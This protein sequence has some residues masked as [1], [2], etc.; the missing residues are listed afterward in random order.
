MNNSDD[1]TLRFNP[2]SPLFNQHIYQIYQRMRRQQPL[3]RIGRTWVLTR[4]QDVSAALRAPQ[5]SCSGI[6]RHL[7]AEF[8]RLQGGLAPE[9]AMLVQEMAL[10]QDNG[11]HRQHRKPLMALFSREPLAQLRR[12][13]VDEINR[14]IAALAKT[15]RLDVIVQLARPLWP[16]LFAR[17]LN[18]S[19]Q[20][21]QVIEQEKESIRLLLDPSAIDRAGLERL[22]SALRRLDT[23]FSQLYQECA[24]G[25]PS[26]FFAALVQGYGDQ[27]ALM[28]RYF[29]AD[30]V[31]ILIGGS[32]TT[33][34]LIGNLMQV[35]A[36]DEPLQQQLRQHPQWIAQAVQ[37]TLRYESPLQMARRTVI[38]PWTLH[39]RTLREQDAV[40]LCLGAANRDETQFCDAQ[41]FDLHRENNSRHLGFGGSAHLCAGQLL[42]RFQA[43]SV[44]AALLQHF[45]RLRPLEQAQW[46][47]DSLIL[48]SLKS[49]PLALG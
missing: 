17:W 42:A 34:A 28:Q 43:E 25:R 14:S 48:R 18:L 33:E 11:T 20:Q 35:V 36:Q 31:T 44:C 22:A 8:A 49:L 40:L 12:L 30:C 6:P 2:A 7:T 39:G 29:S 38:H 3:L 4:Y 21:S 37:E 15:D 9:L 24:D 26:L 27:Q 10:F 46:Q 13:V 45:P 1:R 47:T 41:Q 19:P 32:E 5:L 23:L 16:R